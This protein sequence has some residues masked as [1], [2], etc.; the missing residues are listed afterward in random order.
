MKKYALVVGI[1]KYTDLEITDLTFAAQDARDVADCLC[2]VCG[3]EDVR[4]LLSGGDR[5]PD[6]VNIVD[7]LYNLAP[8]ISHEDL[9]LFYFAGHG[10]ET[11]EGA[12]LLASNSRIHMP[13]LA[14]LS[15]SVLTDC[16]GNVEA[17]SRVLILDACRN[18]P[19]KGMGDADNVLTARF[20]RDVI[21]MAKAPVEGVVPATC[22]LFSCSEGERAYEWPDQGHGAFTHYLLEGLQGAALNAENCL[23]VQNLGR[24]VEERVPRWARKARTPKPQTPWAQQVGSL[25]EI[26]LADT[27]ASRRPSVPPHPAQGH[28]EVMEPPALC[29]ETVPAL[30][31][32]T[33]DG[34]RVGVA[35]VRLTL[36]PGQH[37]IRA[38]KDGYKPWERRIR[39]DGAGDAELR[40]ELQEQPRIAEAFFPMT[41]EQAKEVQAASAGALGVPLTV[42]LDCGAGE[43]LSLILIPAGR[44]LMGSPENEVDRFN[45][46]GPQY[47]AAIRRPFYLGKFPVTQAQY[48]AVTAENPSFFKADTNPVEGVNWHEA[49]RF[50]VGLTRKSA[51]RVCLPT[52]AEWE[53]ACRAGTMDSRYGNLDAISWFEGNSGSMT[54]AVDQKQPNSWGLHDM[55]GNVWEWCEDNW[56][57]GYKNAP[58]DGSAWS[59]GE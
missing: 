34:R 15:M 32:V 53:Y 44:F 8:L 1:S 9:F 37:D 51:H 16:L 5:E 10:V 30:A 11:K 25:R 49:S 18:D 40:I 7:A 38:Q 43:E 55:I 31:Q 26:V 46:E 27:L 41:A 58:S 4:V 42:D 2:Q 52:E 21:A 17:V 6:H 12:R 13:E 22:V 54:H 47:E 29:I 35:P 19:R 57:D 36:P 14:S 3:F 33:V 59:G 48:K 24:Y 50:C 56:H 39:F 28:I 23:T 45:D 20:S